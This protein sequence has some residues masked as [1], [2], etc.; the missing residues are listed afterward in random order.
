MI[1]TVPVTPEGDVDPRFGRAPAM[2]VATVEDGVVAEW[3]V[4][5][6]GWDVLHDEG[7]EGQHHA[8]VVRFMRD[9]KV[10]RVL[11]MGAGPGMLRTLDKLGL[12]LVQVPRMDAREA[13]L[14]A[15]RLDQ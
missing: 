3:Q 2:A 4:H 7:S 9:N 12:S 5:E 14:A 10:E 6:V 13:V 15:A 8:R 1:L 11:L